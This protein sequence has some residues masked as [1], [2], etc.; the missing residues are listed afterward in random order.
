MSIQQ[1]QLS[2]SVGSGS[3]GVEQ[4]L[5]K[6]EYE[7]NGHF[8][9]SLD[10]SIGSSG[11]AAP[12]IDSVV[13]NLLADTTSGATT[14]QVV[15]NATQLISGDKDT[16]AATGWAAAGN[17]TANAVSATRKIGTNSLSINKTS[18]GTEAGYRYDRAAQT[19][20]LA[21][22]PIAFFWI[23]IPD[24]TNLTDVYIKVFADT[25]SNYRKW[26]TTTNAA[27]STVLATGWHLIRV[28]LSSGG[29][30]TGTGWTYTQLSR[31]VEIGVDAGLTQ[32]YTAIL[33]DAVCFGL[34]VTKYG[35]SGAEVTLY[36]T[37]NTQSLVIGNGNTTGDGHFTIGASGTLTNT[38]AGGFTSAARAMFERMST[39]TASGVTGFNSALTG[40]VSL[41]QEL[42]LSRTYRESQTLNPVTVV[43]VTTPQM[44]RVNTVGATT[45]GV[46]DP[47]AMTANLKNTDVVHVF[48]PVYDNGETRYILRGTLTMTADSTATGGTTTLTLTTT[49]IA[50]N[51]LVVKHHLATSFSAV[52]EGANETFSTLTSDASPNGIAIVDGIMGY[53][54][55]A[56]VIAHFRLGALTDAEAG[57]NIKGTLANLTTYSSAGY[58]NTKGAFLA[59]RYSA[60]G[61]G[62]AGPFYTHGNGGALDGVTETPVQMSVWVYVP[63]GAVTGFAGIYVLYNSA[64][65]WRQQVGVDLVNN[66]VGMYFN[67]GGTFSANGS[68]IRDTWNHIFLVWNP[69]TSYLYV[70]GAQTINA[71]P[72]IVDCSGGGFMYFGCEQAGVAIS[73]LRIA[74]FVV[75]SQGSNLTQQQILSIYNAGNFRPFDGPNAIRYKYSQTGITGQRISAKAQLTRT[76]TAV[77]PAILKVGV[78]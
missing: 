1:K 72:S 68:I 73:T 11:M 13:G 32:T 14:L 40:A 42:R 59:G 51:D 19:I 49:G 43:D 25:T 21:G 20:S 77:S 12:F 6:L 2:P 65:V 57:R 55:D 44:Y 47:T 7:K 75:W 69:T 48:R 28:D 30:A 17:A 58:P 24:A 23:N 74:D 38:M 71:T 9:E 45:I 76:T 15:W 64:S 61:W 26:T 22:T 34:D 31:Y 4:L 16:D 29:T 10:N 56:N 78:K 66:R 37:T 27:G 53:P 41:A 3:G 5:Q 18:G 62:S 52:A 36:D 39:S 63:S 35:L 8:T 46:D 50:V 60:T 54:N 33:I 70:N 67:Q